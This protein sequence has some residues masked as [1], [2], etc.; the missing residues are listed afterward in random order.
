MPTNEELLDEIQNGPLKALTAPLILPGATA[1][2]AAILNEKNIEV[3]AE[4][5]AGQRDI[6]NDEFI[7]YIRDN[8]V[9]DGWITKAEAGDIPAKKALWLASN[10]PYDSTTLDQMVADELLTAGQ[11]DELK[12]RELK[13]IDGT[14]KIISRMD[15]LGWSVGSV[16]VAEATRNE[17]YSLTGHP[18][19]GGGS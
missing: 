4:D 12:A 2:I 5:V 13:N 11:K 17:H 1:K 15:Q 14:P 9:L 6:S 19:K 18:Y 8:G 3:V 16:Q 10:L 7:E